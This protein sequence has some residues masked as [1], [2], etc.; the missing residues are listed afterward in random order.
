[1]SIALFYGERERELG[2]ETIVTGNWGWDYDL[3]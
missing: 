1:M 3:L 2:R